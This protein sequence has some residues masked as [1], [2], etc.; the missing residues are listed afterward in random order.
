[1]LLD[2]IIVLSHKYGNDPE[3]VLA[4][5]GNTSVKENGVLYV[6]AS[7]S[8][9]ATADQKSFVALDMAKLDELLRAG[10]PD[11]AEVLKRMLAARLDQSAPR[12]S[13]EA[14][15]HALFRQKFVIHLHP[16]A[17]NAL[18][19]AG[20]GE[21]ETAALFGDDACWMGEI[22]P[23]FTLAIGA[24]KAM[25]RYERDKK[26]PLS[27][28][29][30]QNHGVFFAADSAAEVEALI[31][32]TMDAIRRRFKVVPDLSEVDFDASAAAAVAPALRGLT[33]KFVCFFTNAEIK[34]L[35]A[36][37][38]AVSPVMGAYT[39]DHIVYSG[40]IPCF[41]E[42]DPAAA[43]R[44]YNRK[45]GVSPK[46]ALVRG[47][48]AF[49]LGDSASSANR[50]KALFID[51]V[52]IAVLAGNFGG[53]RFLSP[54]RVAFIRNWEVESYRSKALASDSK[55]RL[56]G[57]VA[58]VTGGAQGFGAGLTC[59][60]CKNGACSVIADINLQGAQALADELCSRYGQGCAVAVKC[61]VGDEGSVK[62]LCERAALAYGGIDIFVS[63]AG[64]LRSGGLGE[65]TVHT[66]EQMT[67]VNYQGFFL[68]AKYASR[69]MKAEHA[70]SPGKFFDIIQINSKSG[71]AGS[72]RNFAYAGG[73]FGGIGLVQSF[74]LELAPY[75]IKVNAICPG[76][77]L[78]GPLWSDPENGLFVQY[79]RAGKVP[80]AKT[81]AD[82]R[83]YYES[84]VPLG[85]GCTP[86]DV[87]TALAY[88]VE[89]L[90]ETGQ[91]LPVTGGQI[92]LK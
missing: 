32:R 49:A 80:G 3:M 59:S 56:A 84:K 21:A 7:G 54:A 43:L 57:K 39:P 70:V 4:G 86:D 62:E 48:G 10:K 55:G 61:D 36:S 47:V 18:T 79:L 78:D 13:V 8:A 81:V 91:A 58:V 1:M 85:R 50:A 34:K 45:Y 5:G 15:L 64:I 90:Y 16:A 68:C 60:L 63:N 20:N 44:A 28:L 9:L 74:A 52:K 46:I 82:V 89:Q 51:S 12:P 83:R 23:G 75:N 76:N 65:M 88:L 42:G 19:C 66:F 77:F 24:Y 11:E 40:H 2:E 33:G 92:M 6:K 38:E 25:R 17:V 22:N 29:F 53:G 35:A 31:E 71:L 87:F 30:L 73:K 67:R 27:L 69:I 26:R 72:K 37:R 14:L 41:I